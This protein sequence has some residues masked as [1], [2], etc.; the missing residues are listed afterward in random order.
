MHVSAI[1]RG[2][3]QAGWNVT[4]LAPGLADG[5]TPSVSLEGEGVTVRWTYP[6][7]R[8]RLPRTVNIVPLLLHLLARSHR[9]DARLAYIRFSPLT[10][11][12]VWAARRFLPRAA[13][14][15]EHNGWVASEASMAGWPAWLCAIV[16]RLQRLDSRL[17]DATRT[18]TEDVMKCL[19]AAGV[20][21][22][23]LFVAE[24]GTDLSRFFPIDRVQ[25]KIDSGLDPSHIHVGFLG[26]LTPW[27][28]V[29]VLLRA[30]ALLVDRHPEVRIVIGGAGGNMEA[31]QALAQELGLADR[32][33]FLGWVSG[34]RANTL[35]NSFDIAVAPYHLPANRPVGSPVKLRDY[36][37]AGRPV[38]AAH[39][40]VVALAS[41]ESWC[42]L[43]RPGD[44]EHLAAR[45]EELLADPQRR[46]VMG[47]LARSHAEKNFSWNAVIKTIASHIPNFRS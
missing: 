16:A 30:A 9:R 36:A 20:P 1:C 19:I 26:T 21:A 43:H 28:G 5:T 3:A 2:L 31:Q 41:D 4:L 14:I 23:K 38:V 15:T 10:P 24:N 25:A 7:N 46:E 47:A 29:D 18:V 33:V 39:Y 12:L 6:V 22:A 45:L 8:W 37:A 34:D 11:L 17:A 27:Q 32:V 35:I 13:I 42:L 40:P 44:H